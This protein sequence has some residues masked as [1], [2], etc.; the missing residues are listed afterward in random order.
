M[1]THAP[2]EAAVG[3]GSTRH[4]V[5]RVGPPHQTPWNPVL[6]LDLSLINKVLSES[7]PRILSEVSADLLQSHV[8]NLPSLHL[9]AGHLSTSSLSAAVTSVGEFT[10]SRQ[11]HGD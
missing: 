7:F 1:G 3:P 10:G 5:R 4:H 2:T 8:Y 6:T 11:G 9:E